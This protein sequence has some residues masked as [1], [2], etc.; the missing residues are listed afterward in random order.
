MAVFSNFQFDIDTEVAISGTCKEANGTNTIVLSKKIDRN[1]TIEFN[2]NALLDE[3]PSHIDQRSCRVRYDSGG[4][5][6]QF[7]VVSLRYNT[8]LI[9]W[10]FDF[11]NQ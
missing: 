5:S 9:I 11:C 6:F 8:T 2:L 1:A 7:F 4:Q 10:R 3:I